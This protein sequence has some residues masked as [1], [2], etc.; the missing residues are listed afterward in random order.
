MF[1]RR[2]QLLGLT[3]A[4]VDLALTAL[5]FILAYWVRA[6]VLPRLLPWAKLPEMFPLGDYGPL[7]FGM[8]LVW[9]VAGSNIN[10]LPT[11][12]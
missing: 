3:C 10:R 9:P 12:D 4:L 2:S 8:L 11:A 5:A 1:A 7:F 6:I